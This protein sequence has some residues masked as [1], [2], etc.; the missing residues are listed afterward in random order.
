[1]SKALTY[2]MKKN[3]PPAGRAGFT[4]IEVI[5]AVSILGI[6][7]FVMASI[8]AKSFNAGDKSQAFGSLKQNGQNIINTLENNI[9]DSQAIV[10]VGQSNN[11]VTIQK[12]DGVFLRY[13][14]KSGNAPYVL[15]EDRPD[16]ADIESPINTKNFCDLN[17]VPEKNPTALNDIDPING[18]SIESLDFK[19]NDTPSGKDSL[20]IFFKLKSLR[21]PTLIEPFQTTV[22]QR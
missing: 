12:K 3:S 15:L 21:D 5:V 19:I 22:F 1:M 6:I 4:L 11:V 14:I 17:L 16:L 8:L 2:V 10:C 18:T 9:R 7:G 20:K 13:S